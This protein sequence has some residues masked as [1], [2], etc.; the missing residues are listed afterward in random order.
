M[1]CHARRG[2]AGSELAEQLNTL[3]YESG[4][5]EGLRSMFTKGISVSALDS[6]PVDL[7]SLAAGLGWMKCRRR[8]LYGHYSIWWRGPSRGCFY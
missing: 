3:L 4:G 6:L 8:V 7:L 1:E 2:E 5:V